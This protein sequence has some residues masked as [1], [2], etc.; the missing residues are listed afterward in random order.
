[1]IPK[2][3]DASTL[4]PFPTSL[5]VSFIGHEHSISCLTISPEGTYLASGDETGLLI[6]WESQ[7]SKPLWQQKYEEPILS[8]DWSPNNLI[9]FSHGSN[10]EIMVWRYPKNLRDKG[11]GQLEEAK[12]AA[13]L[14]K[15]KN[16]TFYDE[17]S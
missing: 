13:N 4:R 14:G 6:I 1:M 10:I 16:W 12:M 8:L 9:G 7:T 11:E 17:K 3:P 15:V 5:N 2:L